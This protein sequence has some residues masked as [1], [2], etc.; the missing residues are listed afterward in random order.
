VNVGRSGLARK[1]KQE[2]TG[3]AD[4]AAIRAALRP[5]RNTSQAGEGEATLDESIMVVDK[6]LARKLAPPPE[7]VEDPTEQFDEEGNKIIPPPP[8]TK[9]VEWFLIKWRG[10]SYLHVSWEVAEDIE[11]VD[12]QGRVKL[13]RFLATEPKL[14][15]ETTNDGAEELKEL[16]FVEPEYIEVQTILNCDTVDPKHADAF[17]KKQS[18]K[19]GNKP[20]KKKGRSTSNSAAAAASA[21]DS[22]QVNAAAAVDAAREQALE[23]EEEHKWWDETTEEDTVKYL[24]KWRGLPYNEATWEEFGLIKGEAHAFIKRFWMRERLPPTVES[25]KRSMPPELK[26]YKTL[27]CSPLFGIYPDKDGHMPDMFPEFKEAGSPDKPNPPSD[28]A[29]STSLSSEAPMVSEEVTKDESAMQDDIS[30]ASAALVPVSSEGSGDAMEVEEMRDGVTEN[31]AAAAEVTVEDASVSAANPSSD[32]APVVEVGDDVEVALEEVQAM[33]LNLRDYQLEGVNWLYWNWFN[34]RPSI[35]ADEMGLGKT[36]QTI[37]YFH[38]LRHS[39]ET[40]L[41]G[42]FLIVAPLSLV[43]QW[44]NEAAVW[45]PDMN[46]IVYHGSGDARTVMQ[47]HEFWY[48]DPYV[49]KDDAV[50]LKKDMVIKT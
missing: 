46:C 2:V 14:F 31:S 18:S 8:S 43:Y 45:A 37:G 28:A 1:Q 32:E 13:R 41:R 23:D 50:A 30:T 5:E 20:I 42:P 21:V 7:P 29:D 12:L 11:A 35:L 44:Q 36:I 24:V 49:P 9:P 4:E 39:P 25:E 15:D 27:K 38:R 3:F 48:R 10:F 22:D 40:K 19:K 26:L 17:G 33:G 47:E 16:E 6:I 34:Q